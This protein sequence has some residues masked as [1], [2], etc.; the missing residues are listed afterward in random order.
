MEV[1]IALLLIFLIWKYHKR[2][3]QAPIRAN[4]T[5]MPNTNEKQLTTVQ[6]PIPKE[7][8]GLLW[9]IDGP[10][11]N[12]ENTPQNQTKSK[13]LTDLGELNITCSTYHIA[14][15]SAI[16]FN[17]EIRKPP[18]ELNVE[19]PS[20]FPSYEEITPHQRWIYLNWLRNIY[21]PI[22]I[23]YVFIFYYGLERHLYWGNFEKAIETI[24]KL[25]KAHPNPSF[26]SYSANALIFSCILYRRSDLLQQVMEECS[27]LQSLSDIGLF[28]RHKVKDTLTID[29]LFRLAKAFKLTNKKVIKENLP[30]FIEALT[31]IL[32][33]RYGV[34][35]YPLD[36]IDL[37]SCPVS[38]ISAA[39][40]IS[41]ESLRSVNIPCIRKSSYLHEEI[42]LLFC[43]ANSI[44]NKNVQQQHNPS[45][46]E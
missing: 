40:N 33:E 42:K 16:S 11:Q 31:L 2:R 27:E 20:Y 24:L 37:K 25:R 29:E 14:E 17:V 1:I 36:K 13:I 45:K 9:F 4:Y 6:Y 34:A 32:R 30:V 3:K 7:I 39:A 12:Y 38:V 15:P 43:E 28:V 23:G 10:Y 26:L 5:Q 21:Q 19:S 35:S 44:A 18:P 8:Q 41:L 46:V 22:H